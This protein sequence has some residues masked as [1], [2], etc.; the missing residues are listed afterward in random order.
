MSEIK[1]PRINS[2]DKKEEC[3]KFDDTS[4]IGKIL[5]QIQLKKAK[6]R[7][8]TMRLQPNCFEV[9]LLLLLLLSFFVVAVVVLNVDIKG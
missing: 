1:D 4:E 5:Y 2:I 6:T 7:L 8:I 9:V 3:F